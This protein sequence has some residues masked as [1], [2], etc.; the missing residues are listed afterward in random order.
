MVENVDNCKGIRSLIQASGRR[1]SLQPVTGRIAGCLH[2][3]LGLAAL[4]SWYDNGAVGTRS[5]GRSLPDYP[6]DR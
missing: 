6:A 4:R 2:E 3:W 1:E 5:H